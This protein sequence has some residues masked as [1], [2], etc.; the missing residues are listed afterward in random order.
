MARHVA[1]EKRLKSHRIFFETLRRMARMLEK[2]RKLL[3]LS[4]NIKFSKIDHDNAMVATVYKVESSGK[5]RFI[6]KICDRPHDYTNEVYFL[7]HFE[8]QIQVPAIIKILPPSQENHGA[9]LMEYLS[10]C[11]LRPS[12]ITREIAFQLGKSLA[13]IHSNKTDGFGYLK[14]DAELVSE[15]TSHFKEKFLEGIDECKNH[16]PA[17]LIVKLRHYFDKTQHLIAKADGPC[18]IH[19]DFRPGN[20]ILTNHRLCGVIDWSSARASFAEDDFCPIEHGEWGDFNHYKENF[21]EGYSRIRK[22]PEYHQLMP[23]LRLNRAIAVIGFTVKRNTWNTTNFR[24]YQFNRQFL[25][26]VDIF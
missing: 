2:Y 20:I 19:R 13:I 11:L 22:I 12:L 26:S 18:L 16:L 6:L 24:P 5:P 25:G 10:G 23:L 17:D 1:Y 3:N 15:P 7:S 4:K 14:R 8:K 21:L 9:I